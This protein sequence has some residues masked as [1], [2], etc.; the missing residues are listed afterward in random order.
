[1][2]ASRQTVGRQRQDKKRDLEHT[3]FDHDLHS[4][5]W[6]TCE[7]IDGIL[8]RCGRQICVELDVVGLSGVLD[9]HLQ[10]GHDCDKERSGQA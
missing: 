7:L 5:G 8:E 10:R 9:V 2:R 4:V 6:Y 1:M 3:A